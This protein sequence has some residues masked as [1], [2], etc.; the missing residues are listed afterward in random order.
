GETGLTEIQ[1]DKENLL[2][3]LSKLDGR[4]AVG[5]DGI[6]GIILRE[7]KEELLLP[8]H[9]IIESSLREGRVPREWK[10]A[11]IV[12][13]Y[14]GGNIE[15]PLNYRPV[16]LTSVMC[17][18]CEGIIKDDW[19]RY[20]ESTNRITNAQSGFRKGK[21]CVTNLLSFYSRVIDEVQERDGWVDCVYLDLK[22]AFDK[23]PHTK[24]IWKLENFGG[25]KERLLEWM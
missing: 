15:N 17:K 10:R 25:V 11:H 24:L 3:R 23:V 22:K 4:K 2:D 21:S 16:S 19:I 18:I 8:V 6:A 14:K 1:V 12:P 9:S 5:P 7:C 20:L 13:I